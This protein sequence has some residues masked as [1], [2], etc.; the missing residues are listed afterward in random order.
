MEITIKGNP[1][2]IAD[3]VLAVQSRQEQKHSPLEIM[4]EAF[5]EAICDT[6]EE[7]YILI[8]FEKS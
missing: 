2:E 3:L 4:Q 5:R 6:G 8:F 1:K 7:H